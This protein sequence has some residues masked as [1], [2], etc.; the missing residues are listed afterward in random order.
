MPSAGDLL[1][2]YQ[3][4]R[5]IGA[6]GMG[7][8]YL[9]RDTRLD[10]LAAIKILPPDL[11]GDAERVARFTQ[12]ARLAS[13]LNHP[14]IG[15]IY[16]VGETGGV[17][18]IAMEYV[19]GD[20]LRHR[21]THGP[22]P[23]AAVIDIAV[24][25]AEALR[26]AHDGGVTH[27]DIKPDN[28]MMR[29]DGLVKVLDFGIAKS[30]GSAPIADHASTVQAG[31][32]LPGVVVGTVNY[33]SPEQARGLAV[34]PR[35]DIFSLGVVLFEA[36]TSRRPFAGETSLDVLA[37]ILNRDP[38]VPSQYVSAVPAEMDRI[39]R[40]AMRKDPDERYSSSQELLTDIKAL[41]REWQT[42][43][44][45]AP[46]RSRTARI[47]VG[48]AAI[49]VLGIAAIGLYP[50]VTA[51]PRESAIESI[52][53][54]PFTSSGGDANL[55]YLADGL[56]ES[57]TSN[58]S[59]LNGLR[60]MARSSAD[61][62]K[63]TTDP[64][65]AG[66]DLGV[67][68][69]LVGAVAPRGDTVTINLELIDVAD[70]RQLWG[71]Q[72]PRPLSDLVRLQSDI[73]R[74]VAEHLR[75]ALTGAEQANLQRVP[76][77]NADAY[78]LYLR[79]RYY[80]HQ[81]TDE[82]LRTA[83]DLYSQ[84]LQKDPQFVMAH[85]ALAETYIAQGV[86]FLPAREVMPKATAHAVRAL[87]L[88]PDS[89]DAHAALG[90]VKLVYDWD[91]KGAQQELTQA[92]AMDSPTIE[93][94]TCALHYA[95]P[96]GRN[97]DAVAALQSAVA[98]EPQSLPSNLELGCASYYGRDY[99]QAIRQFR[100]T[101]A[102]YPNHASAQYFLGRAMVQ[103]GE[104]AAAI[105]QLEDAKRTSGSWPPIVAELGYAHARDGQRAEARTALN[106]L[107][108]QARRRFVDPY[109]IAAVH[110]GLGDKD[111]AIAALHQAVE[112][113][114]GWLPWLKVEPK[115]DPLHGDARFHELL[116]QVG[117]P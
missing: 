47:A 39:V 113:R 64:L 57:V 26:A 87:E 65:Q 72:Y 5:T 58:L 25:V 27:R 2:A 90:I 13:S 1:G 30:T 79:G 67:R 49:V 20:T 83:V 71:E 8:V 15:T 76:T 78:Q 19:E 6:G 108:E 48:A 117:L 115:W 93:S 75:P 35:T 86:D 63:G 32:T 106:E 88:A 12:E 68:A 66:R 22:L 110:I 114:S 109:L 44:A 56:A 3:V 112:A 54:L 89:A 96:L 29:P 60:V 4:I 10:R 14:G 51:D 70:G 81:L 50:G 74:A 92:H 36:L 9:A 45:V 99:D 42:A 85:V 62:Y 84:A 101:L 46:P 41:R 97:Q 17:R 31:P 24:Q 61:R 102:L 37:A 82:S 21:L 38:G 16:D 100:G 105:S 80:A 94:F 18:F 53:V 23:V 95:D 69:V 34:D 111:A 107:G 55:A 43:P 7:E 52:V 116:R 98:A 104:L 28:L 11:S 103:K 77:A 40:K 91:W 33:M 59:R 73:S